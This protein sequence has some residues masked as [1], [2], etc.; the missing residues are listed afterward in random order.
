M[1]KDGDGDENRYDVF[2]TFSSGG[3]LSGKRWLGGLLVL[4]VWGVLH[5][6]CFCTLFFVSLFSHGPFALWPL[7]LLGIR[8]GLVA[9]I[10][11]ALR[12][13]TNEA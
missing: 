13:R 6:M 9:E 1:M 7:A 4:G 12:L 3:V 11:L 5:L 10:G 2:G 8:W